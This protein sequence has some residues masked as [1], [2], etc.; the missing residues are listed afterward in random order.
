MPCNQDQ[1]KKRR[2]N[3][4]RNAHQNDY[5]FMQQVNRWAFS[6][7]TRDARVFDGV[8]IFGQCEFI[9]RNIHSHLRYFFFLEMSRSL[10][11]VCRRIQFRHWQLLYKS[12]KW[13]KTI[14]SILFHCW[15]IVLGHMLHL[16][17]VSSI[18]ESNLAYF[19]FFRYQERN[20]VSNMK[21]K[22][23]HTLQNY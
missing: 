15:F 13:R 19:F 8:S 7:I 5:V 12:N 4:T 18:L 20:K 21:I 3:E 16:L 17:S 14:I 9:S 11:D 2:R 22:W 6:P 23:R 10:F 1:C